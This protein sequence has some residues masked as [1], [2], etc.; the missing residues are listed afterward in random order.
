MAHVDLHMHTVHSDGLATPA[1]MAARARDLGLAGIALTDHDT[2]AGVPE[3]RAAAAEAGIE[4]LSGTEISTV[5]EDTEVHVVGLGF[6]ITHEPLLAA[7]EHLRAGRATRAHGI[8]V[9][10]RGLGLPIETERVEARAHPGAIGRLHIAMELRALGC[11]STAQEAFNRF[12]NPGLPAF[13]P[14]VL[15]PAAEAIRLVQESGGLA[16]IAHPGLSPNTRRLLPRLL[17]LPIDGIEAYHISHSPART[18]EY[19]ALA[20]Q[21]RLLVSGGSDCHG[22]A[23]GAREL[24]KVRVPIEHLTALRAALAQR[25][26]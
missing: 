14:K 18:K 11:I 6:E 2:V 25:N 8:L 7:L 3:G 13:V 10:L 1:E 12:L 22:G 9:K 5:F 24:G 20:K 21:R 16:F 4:F 23:K 15:I 19:L 26:S 17:E